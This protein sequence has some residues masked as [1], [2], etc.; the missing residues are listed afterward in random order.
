M[1]TARRSILAILLLVGVQPAAGAAST[2]APNPYAPWRN[3]PP[4]SSDYFPIAVWL[5][6]P[7]NAERFKAAG[8][9]L[10]VGLW[11]GPTE[12]QLD[13]LRK[14]G[15]PVIC[16]QNEVGL[17]HRDDPIIVGW[18]HGDEPD[19]AQVVRDRKSVV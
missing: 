18:M 6:N 13:A 4:R 5:Q 1:K 7:R 14:A 19:N 12:A 3:G 2:T 8:I 10:Y 11:K 16:A 9:N 17:A 15:M